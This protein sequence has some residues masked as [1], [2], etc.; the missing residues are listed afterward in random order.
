VFQNAIP[1]HLST[2]RLPSAT[3]HESEQW[4]YMLRNMEASPKKTSILE[5]YVKGFESAFIMMTGIA[6]SAWWP[7]S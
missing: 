5:S 7:A 1:G 6:T 3:A 4:V 2:F